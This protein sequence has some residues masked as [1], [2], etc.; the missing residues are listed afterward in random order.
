MDQ[1]PTLTN[2]NELNF[3]QTG[4]RPNVAVFVFGAWFALS[5]SFILAT[6]IFARAFPWLDD[7]A[8]LPFFTDKAPLILDGFWQPHNEPQIPLPRLLCWTTLSRADASLL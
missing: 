5:V 7:F 1:D 4:P 2:Q 3:G 8:F 6:V